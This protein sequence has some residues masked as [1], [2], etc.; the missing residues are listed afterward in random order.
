MDLPSVPGIPQAAF[1]AGVNHLLAAHSWATEKLQPYAGRR[2]IL[3]I[4]PFEARFVIEDSG[5][6][7]GALGEDPFDATLI[8][9]PGALAK[10]FASGSADTGDLQTEG[11]SGIAVDVANVLRGLRWD[12]EEDLSLLVGDIAAHRLVS[13]GK[14][15]LSWKTRAAV[16]VGQSLAEYWTEEKPL[17]ARAANIQRFTAEV[18][19]VRDAVERLEKRIE[20]LK[21]AA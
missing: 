19:T 14:A 4:P 17:L 7:A 18:D 6:L 11:D 2:V 9:P 10:H 16:A 1:L 8:L 3:R 13:L 5:L 21:G 20:R 12:A 15:F